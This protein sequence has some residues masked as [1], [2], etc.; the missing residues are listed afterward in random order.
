MSSIEKY[1][2]L[3]RKIEI[4]DGLTPDE[5][6]SVLKLGKSVKFQNNLPIFHEGQVASNLFIV[7]K[8]EVDLYIKNLLIAKCRQGDAVGVMEGLTH[9][10]HRS[11]AVA[12]GDARVFVLNDDQIGQLMGQRIAVQLLLNIIHLLSLQLESSF[13]HYALLC[14]EK[15]RL[16]N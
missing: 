14:Q 10:P 15:K 1:A 11:T 2:R 5:V 12:N 16:E 3:A 4:F 7:L 6:R 9:R 13:T 8:G